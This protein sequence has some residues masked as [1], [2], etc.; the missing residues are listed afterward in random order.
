VPRFPTAILVMGLMQLAV[1]CGAVGLILHE[2]ASVR[3]EQKLLRYLDF[4]SPAARHE[5]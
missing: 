1:I 5:R 4:P 3:R 2:L